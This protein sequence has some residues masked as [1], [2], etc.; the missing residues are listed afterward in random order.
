MCRP[1]VILQATALQRTE[2]FYRLPIGL[3]DSLDHVPVTGILSMDG[4]IK[5]DRVNWALAQMMSVNPTKRK[6]YVR[7]KHEFVIKLRTASPSCLA[8]TVLDKSLPYTISLRQSSAASHIVLGAAGHESK[9][10]NSKTLIHFSII[11]SAAGVFLPLANV[12]L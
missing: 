7:D 4:S 10:R 1:P 9:L 5:R 2:G 6:P 11:C 12:C 8:G 3:E